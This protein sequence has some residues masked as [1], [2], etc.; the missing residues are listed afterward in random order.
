MD[1]YKDPNL[2]ESVEFVEIKND[3]CDSKPQRS[4]L[5]ESLSQNILT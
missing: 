3:F 4:S 1:D 5:P 2:E